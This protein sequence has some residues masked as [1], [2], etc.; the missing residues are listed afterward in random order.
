MINVSKAR[1]HAILNATCIRAPIFCT[2][3]RH[4]IVRKSRCV[5][6]FVFST[7]ISSPL[8]FFF[9]F[10]SFISQKLVLRVPNPGPFYY[11]DY[12]FFLFSRLL[13]PFLPLCILSLSLFLFFFFFFFFHF[14]SSVSYALR[15]NICS[16]MHQL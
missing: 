14:H 15:S 11:F 12:Y 13:S 8:S 1:N 10:F 9:Y 16:H 4:L 2:R 5:S 6:H 7:G 3:N